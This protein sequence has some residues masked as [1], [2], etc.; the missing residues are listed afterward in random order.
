MS[1]T[2]IPLSAGEQ[3]DLVAQKVKQARGKWVL[4]YESGGIHDRVVRNERVRANLERRGLKVE[5]R[6]RI[7]N[8]TPERPWSG[9]RT[10]A[11]T[12]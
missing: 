11:R 12:I 3:W 2:D 5:V 9:V 8:D 1:T 4:V 6:S 7:G 10:F